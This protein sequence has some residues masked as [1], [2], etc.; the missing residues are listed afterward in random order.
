MQAEAVPPRRG[1]H[2][3][4]DTL[5]SQVSRRKRSGRRTGLT[6][7]IATGSLCDCAGH[8]PVPTLIVRDLEPRTYTLSLGYE[9]QGVRAGLEV[10]WS[11]EPLR[12]QCTPCD[13]ERWAPQGVHC[14]LQ[15]E[16]SEISNSTARCPARV[17]IASSGRAIK[18]D[19]SPKSPSS[20]IGRG[21]V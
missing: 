1:E 10:G 2:I 4:P 20:A 13:E 8:L 5:A 19:K 17:Q 3:D 21:E 7:I 18:A 12:R 16:D 6:S 14:P 15:L 11:G 9:A